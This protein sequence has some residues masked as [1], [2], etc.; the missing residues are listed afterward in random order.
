MTSMATATTIGGPD[1]AT[2]IAFVIGAGSGGDGSSSRQI[3]ILAEGTPGGTGGDDEVSGVLATAGD[4]ETYFGPQSPGAYMAHAIFDINPFAN[5]RC[6]RV[7]PIAVGAGEVKATANVVFAGGPAT[8]TGTFTLDVGGHLINIPV[9]SGETDATVGARLQQLWNSR[10]GVDRPPVTASGGGAT[11]AMTSTVVGTLMNSCRLVRVTTGNE[12]GGMTMTPS[13]TTLTG[14]LTAGYSLTAIFTAL[15][16]VRTPL[17][18]S[19]WDSAA[20]VL[21]IKNHCVTKSNPQD[22]LWSNMVN[23]ET[24]ATTSAITTLVDAYDDERARTIG[25]INN[26]SLSM[27]IAADY[28]AAISSSNDLPLPVNGVPL[29]HVRVPADADIMGKAERIAALN[30]GWCPIKEVDGQMV[31][32]RYIIS[33]YDLGVVDAG[34]IDVLDYLAT[35]FAAT[36]A[37]LGPVKVIPVGSEG[38]GENTITLDGIQS[39]VEA[40]LIHVQEEDGFLYDVKPNLAQ[41]ATTYEGGGLVR[42][43]IPDSCLKV[44][45]GLHNTIIEGTHRVDAA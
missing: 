36:F 31:V 26:R 21:L 32:T 14:G 40:D 17:L 13:A 39:L 10:T 7:K 12:P 43:Q 38:G 44:T 35:R 5:V 25:G 6:A 24:G 37:A 4:C 19:E 28:A 15:A 34:A 41:I 16:N 9:V 30:G 18:V 42:V 8:S 22:Q 1:P 45:P 20:E 23:A 27:L 3:V 11:I 29:K 2:E 33:R